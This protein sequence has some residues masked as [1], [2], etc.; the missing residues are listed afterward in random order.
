MAYA[1]FTIQKGIPIPPPGQWGRAIKAFPFLKMEVGDSFWAPGKIHKL[2][3]HNAILARDKGMEFVSR[4]E[5]RDGIDGFRMW[6]I[7]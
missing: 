1:T 6:R 3:S 2:N 5:Q 7:K 4:H